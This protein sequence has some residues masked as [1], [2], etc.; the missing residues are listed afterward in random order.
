MV[1]TVVMPNMLMMLRMKVNNTWIQWWGQQGKPRRTH[2]QGWEG[3]NW[4]T[5]LSIKQSNMRITKSEWATQ[6]SSLSPLDTVIIVI[7][8]IVNINLVKIKGHDNDCGIRPWPTNSNEMELGA[9]TGRHNLHHC[10]WNN[11]KVRLQVRQEWQCYLRGGWVIKECCRDLG[12][13]NL[14]GSHLH[15]DP[16]AGGARSGGWTHL[17][18]QS[19]KK[20]ILFLL[21]FTAHLNE[22]SVAKES[23]NLTVFLHPPLI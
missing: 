4:V 21:F 5:Q 18:E 20:V 6:L 12:L 9:V 22:Q 1:V 10:Q 8:M 13:H 3:S 15:R 7:A 16:K 2:Y 23:S 19:V 17:N 14:S 11:Q